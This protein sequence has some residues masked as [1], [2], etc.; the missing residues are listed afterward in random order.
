[1]KNYLNITCNIDYRRQVTL[2]FFQD[3][4][5]I[6]TEILR[7]LIRFKPSC[8]SLIRA[9]ISNYMLCFI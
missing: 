7:S 8:R 2:I 9:L 4:A 6:I 5:R 3:N 1:M